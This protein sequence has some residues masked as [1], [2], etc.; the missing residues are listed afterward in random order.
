MLVRRGDLAHAWR[1]R[2]EPVARLEVAQSSRL[3]ATTRRSLQEHA[4]RRP[5]VEVI[6]QDVGLFNG[7]RPGAC[8][9]PVRSRFGAFSSVHLCLSYRL[10]ALTAMAADNGGWCS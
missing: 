10:G 1:Q 4:R 3:R 2:D 8:F 7:R 9:C 6:H 5:Q